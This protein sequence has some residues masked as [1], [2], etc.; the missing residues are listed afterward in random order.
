MTLCPRYE[1]E[2]GSRI[3]RRSFDMLLM[4]LET[5]ITLER[6]SAKAQEYVR[7]LISETRRSDLPPSEDRHRRGWHYWLFEAEDFTGD[8]AYVVQA[9]GPHCI[10]RRYL[11]A[12]PSCSSP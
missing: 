3:C 8:V 4:S 9:V 10:G 12:T 6:R 11:G 1:Y 7:S 2:A 5:L